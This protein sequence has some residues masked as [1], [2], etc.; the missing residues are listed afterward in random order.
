MAGEGGPL[1][2]PARLPTRCLR[3]E[4][5]RSTQRAADRASLT[6]ECS[7][8]R[9]RTHQDDHARKSVRD[10]IAVDRRYV[11]DSGC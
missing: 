4:P 6:V 9:P 3:A 2:V 7:P 5:L 8:R 11:L 10:M 1:I